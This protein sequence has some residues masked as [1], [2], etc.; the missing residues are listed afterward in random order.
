M[1]QARADA[2]NYFAA[3]GDKAKDF[4]RTV[5]SGASSARA[6]AMQACYAKVRVYT[7]AG[8]GGAAAWFGTHPGHG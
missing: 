5:S 2:K 3:G 7:H 6:A 4:G 8:E 1:A